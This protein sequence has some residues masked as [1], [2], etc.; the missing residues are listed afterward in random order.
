VFKLITYQAKSNKK[1]TIHY[2]SLI[3]PL[4]GCSFWTSRC[5]ANIAG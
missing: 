1:Y 2:G 5:F 4:W 3:Q